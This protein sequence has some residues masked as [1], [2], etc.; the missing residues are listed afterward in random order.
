M[1][2]GP[3]AMLFQGNGQ[4]KLLISKLESFSLCRRQYLRV[5]ECVGKTLEKLAQDSMMKELV[6]GCV[7]TR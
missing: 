7:I 3:F 2:D 6:K 4:H 1:R 5:S